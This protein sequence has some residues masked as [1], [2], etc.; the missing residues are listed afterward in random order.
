VAEALLFSP[1]TL[2]G[3]T[4]RNRIVLSP[5]CQYLAEDGQVTD[6]HL[7]H[8]GKFATSGLGLG[9]VE[10]TAVAREGR[11]THGCLGLWEDGQIEGLRR[12]VELYH[13]HG[14]KAAIQINHAGRKGS[15]ER[16]WDGAGTIPQR[17]AEGPWQTVAPSAL[18]ARPG[19]HVPRELRADEIPPLIAAFRDAARRALA[20][21]FDIL[22][23]HGAH[24]YLIHSF[25]SPLSNTRSD[26][27]GGDLARRIR[28]PL[29]VA[30]AVRE[31]W[32]EDRPL[33]YRCSVQDGAPGGS[34][35]EDSATLARELAARGVDLFDC[36]SGGMLSPATLG[37]TH[38]GPGYQVPLARAMRQMA[39]IPAMAVGF[40]TEAHQAEA[41]L[42]EGSADLIAIG[43]EFLAAPYWPYHAALALGLEQAHALLPGPYAF[44]LARRAALSRPSPAAA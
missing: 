4:L 5:M 35:L 33:F 29:L 27:W 22:E 39:G 26:A 7:I 1:F 23:I 20:A 44:Y 21:G 13:R 8:H 40:I 32:P 38:P 37:T 6:W 12:I 36:S 15:T 31:V 10:A 24:G 43:R 16:P 9:F 17:E 25:V 34:T 11:I 41:I 14:A 19:W 28:F 2:R 3:V 30:E 18:P 42:R